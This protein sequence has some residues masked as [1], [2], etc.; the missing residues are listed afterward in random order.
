MRKYYSIFDLTNQRVGLAGSSYQEPFQITFV[1]LAAIIGIVIMSL[2]IVRVVC[3][4]C[5]KNRRHGG[6]GLAPVGPQQPQQQQ[7]M[8][9]DRGDF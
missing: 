7:Q 5:Q 9:D 4:M 3:L 6:S 8:M 2:V 1:M